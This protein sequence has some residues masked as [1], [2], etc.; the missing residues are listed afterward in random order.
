MQ[1]TAEYVRYHGRLYR[2]VTVHTDGT[3]EI[4]SAGGPKHTTVTWLTDLVPV[5]LRSVS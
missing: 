3:A 2:L 1:P 5:A 4:R